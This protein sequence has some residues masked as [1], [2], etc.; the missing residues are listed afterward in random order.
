[1]MRVNAPLIAFNRGVVGRLALARL[2]VDR[3]QLSAQEQINWMPRVIGSMMVRP[4]L[5]Y[6]DPVDEAYFVPFVF[7]STE[8]AL[9]EFSSNKLRIWTDDALLQ[10]ESTTAVITN[11]AFDTDLTG[12]T[13][14]DE[15]DAISSWKTG[16]FLSLIGSGFNS[17]KRQQEITVT[18]QGRAHGIRI[19]VSRGPVRFRAGSSAGDDEYINADLQSGEHSLVA[20]PS[21][22]LFI[23]FSSELAREVLIESVEIETVGAVELPTEFETTS[24][25]RYGQ[26]GDV[27][28]IACQ[29]CP[30]KVIERRDDNS[31]SIVDYLP[32]DG[33]Y[34]LIN[35]TSTTIFPSDVSGN[36]TLTAS[37]P[38]FDAEHVGAIFRLESSG[39]L[40]QATL[41][42]EDQFTEGVR[43]TGLE[44]TRRY[45]YTIIGD[46]SGGSI[47][48]I[49]RRIGE[50]GN[51]EDVQSFSSSIDGNKNDDR[52]N[53][54]I[55]YRAG[56]KAGD[57][58]GSDSIE[59]SIFFNGGSSSGVARIT[60]FTSDTLVDAE[61]LEQLGNDEATSDWY[62]GLWSRKRGYPSSVALAE[63]RLWWFG[64]N[65]IVGSISDDFESFD[66]DFEGDAGPIN[67]VIGRG[68][69]DQIH[70]AL[71]L[72]RIMIGTAGSELSL[73]SSSLDEPLTPTGFTFKDSS[74]Q[75]SALIDAVQLDREAMFVQR[76][77][78]RMYYLSV[79][80][81]LAEYAA[82]DMTLLSPDILLPGVKRLSVQRQP[83]TRV[84]AVLTDGTVR[85]LVFDP[86]EDVRAW[87]T[88]ETDGLVEDVVTLPGLVEDQ[89]YYVVNRN[90]RR[91]LE[92]WALESE[93]IGAA[94]T[95][96]GDAGLSFTMDGETRL[97]GLEHLEGKEVVLWGNGKDLGTY[98][99][100][101]GE[102]EASEEL[103]GNAYVGLPY[104]ARYKSSK[105]LYGAQG[106]ALSMP[107][108]INKVSLVM[109]DVHPQ[110]VKVGPSYD[111]LDDMPL[112]TS[113]Y[114]NLNQ[115]EIIPEY[116]YKAVE[117]AG[118][119]EVDPRLC[120]QGAAPRPCT[121]LA[122]VVGVETNERN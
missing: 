51:W 82:T 101:S 4:G 18:E 81:G 42:G 112:R 61:V 103:N 17:A 67:R 122:A 106:T 1:M 66:P 116:D 31:W 63:G 46:F 55:F 100:V 45:F 70:W 40:V 7:S 72:D 95:R 26:S 87:I 102:I 8:V 79:A 54:V 37:R 86:L 68:P 32:E 77:G 65:R 93:A 43:I 84:H 80:Q 59:A 35:N 83:D 6:L 108:R 48:T 30:Q 62:E 33:P 96:M 28:F 71:P 12:W 74:T 118:D 15:T 39:Q 9:L 97:T 36:I 3:V 2:D 16:G 90:G 13:D 24:Q 53:A 110:G 38:I 14:A 21:G 49:Q 105:M 34:R 57:Y 114:P 89:V 44:G 10:R 94:D 23:E 11:G 111:R 85:V 88:I 20:V 91:G 115:D 104:T 98:T 92:K 60:G 69:V 121:V 75:G 107:K 52:D 113:A 19:K 119:H 50:T 120:L 109:A 56:I 64:K 117:F 25:I 76:S 29:G 47:V 73:R 22:N 27:V 99:V 78:T 58:A 41:S 5:Q